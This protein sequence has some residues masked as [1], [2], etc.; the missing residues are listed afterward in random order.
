V[1]PRPRALLILNPNATTTDAALRD[2]IVAALSSEVDLEVAP[3][4]QRGHATHLAAGAVHAGVDVVFALG[5]DGTANEVIQ[6]LAGT[7]V[8][9]GLIPG[10]GTNVFARALGLPNDAVAATTRLLAALRADR[11]RR[12]GLG[13]AGGRWFGFNAGLGFDGAIVRHVEQRDRLKRT[14]RQGAFVWGTVREWAV[15]PSRRTPLVEATFEDGTRWGP[16]AVA[17]V[18]NTDPYTY[19]GDRAMHVHP[20]AS[21]DRGLDLLTIDAV[22]TARLL[23]I[24]AGAFR[25]GRHLGMPGVRYAR[26]LP[27]FTLASAR[28]QPLE[29]DGDYAGEHREVRFTA[30]PHALSVL[31]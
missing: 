19:L 26:D 1:D 3:T 6:S 12:I 31:H 4:K 20:A 17:L 18:A 22:P 24:V 7:S 11:S 10:G 25:A 15:G 27:A 21:F 16:V 28:P 29:V 23:S 8:R 14:L 13:R 2:L 9:L 5:G 30:V